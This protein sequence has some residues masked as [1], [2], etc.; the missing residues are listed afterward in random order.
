MVT[1]YG[2]KAA[3]RMAQLLSD[4]QPEVDSAMDQIGELVGQDRRALTYSVDATGT[5]GSPWGKEDR[6]QMT[7]EPLSGL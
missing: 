4:I 1:V 7:G 5:D 3:N 6:R 2:Y